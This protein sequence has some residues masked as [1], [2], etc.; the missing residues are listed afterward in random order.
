MAS[1]SS[2]YG[3]GV[4]LL[5]LMPDGSEKPIAQASRSLFQREKQYAQIEKEAFSVFDL[6]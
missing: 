4:V 3:L 1:G 5:H 6:P 2:A